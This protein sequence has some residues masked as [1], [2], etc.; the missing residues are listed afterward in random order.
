VEIR[1]LEIFL[2]AAKHLNFTRAGEE[3]HL[4]QPSVSVRIRQLESDLG[5][6]LFEQLGKK[7]A[8]TEAGRLLVPYALR[9]LA[10]ADDA[11]HAVEE[12]QGLA[13]GSLKVGASTTPGMYVL[14]KVIAEFKSLYPGVEVHLRVKDTRQVEE[15]VIRNEFDF[16]FVGGHLV[17]DEVKVIPW[18]T[19]ELLLIVPPRHPLAKKRQVR[20]KD[21][22]RERFILR[23]Q[24]SATQA[25][26]DSSLRASGVQPEPVIEMEN[27]ESVKRAVQSGLGV[28]FVSRFAVETELKARALAAVTVRDLK[29]RREMKIVHRVGKHLSKA[30]LAFIETAGK[31]G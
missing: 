27:P 13:R 24:G 28:A 31:A 10:A 5:V 1:D 7:I 22:T 29:I 30:A 6:K 15:G 8:L 2:C 16:G 14:P 17:G 23:E 19:D 11:R 25:A 18:L 3:L 9:V 26:V 21:L 4:S 12:L 20:A